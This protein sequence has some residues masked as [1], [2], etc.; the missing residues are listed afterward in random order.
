MRHEQGERGG[1]KNASP[2][3]SVRMHALI[4]MRPL[5]CTTMPPI[6]FGSV[7]VSITADV[8]LTSVT[9]RTMI[10][11]SRASTELV[12]SSKIRK[13][14]S[15]AVRRLVCRDRC[16]M[17]RAAAAVRGCVLLP[18][19]ARVK[20]LA[21]LPRRFGSLSCR[22]TNACSLG[23]DWP[24]PLR[25]RMPLMVNEG[26][27]EATSALDAATACC[28]LTSAARLAGLGEPRPMMIAISTNQ[29]PASHS[30]LG[31]ADASRPKC[32][33]A[34]AASPRLRVRRRLL[35]GW[36]LGLDRAPKMC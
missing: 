8:V 36:D 15:R 26:L 35:P 34:F 6:R 25:R 4:A 14:R 28:R 10:A 30:G 21:T 33:A 27:P 11:K 17:S 24:S 12:G 18:A 23:F 29:T 22:D 3:H 16:A 2:A 19:I 7:Q 31:L 5:D 13:S 32:A 9:T 1:V 20:R